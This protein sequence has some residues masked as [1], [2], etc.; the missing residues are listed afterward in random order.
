MVVTDEALGDVNMGPGD[1]HLGTAVVAAGA[2]LPLNHA[3][4]CD[5]GL[6]ARGNIV[7][8]PKPRRPGVKLK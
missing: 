4:P 7:L 6:K 1:T 5:A 3:V 2:K 8:G